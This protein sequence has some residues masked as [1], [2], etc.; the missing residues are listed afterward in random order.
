MP[1]CLFFFLRILYMCIKCFD[2]IYPFP[3]PQMPSPPFFFPNSGLFFFFNLSLSLCLSPYHSLSLSLPLSHFK[4]IRFHL[5]L[6]LMDM[7]HLLEMGRRSGL[8]TGGKF[9]LSHQLSITSQ[10]GMGLHVP[11]SPMM[12]F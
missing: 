9:T 3:F 12:L 11:T 7:E 6:P 1:F 10:L 5:L 2:Q 4:S 8:H